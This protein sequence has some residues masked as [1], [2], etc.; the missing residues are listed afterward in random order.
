MTKSTK[1][2]FKGG[3]FI[4]IAIIYTKPLYFAYFEPSRAAH[5]RVF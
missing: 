3:F 4:A 1:T 2:T 5:N